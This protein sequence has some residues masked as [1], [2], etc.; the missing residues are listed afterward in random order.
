MEQTWSRRGAECANVHELLAARAPWDE[1]AAARGGAEV[2]AEV[3]LLA[4]AVAVQQ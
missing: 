3:E 2:H 4:A 1:G